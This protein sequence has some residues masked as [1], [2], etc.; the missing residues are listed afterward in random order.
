MIDY[1]GMSIPED[2]FFK[3]TKYKNGI[4]LVDPMN[5]KKTVYLRDEDVQK[6]LKDYIRII[7]KKE[8]K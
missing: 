3:V 4:G 7:L 5:I 8:E 6:I 1:S 2:K